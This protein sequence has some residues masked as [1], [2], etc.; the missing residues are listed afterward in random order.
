M[1]HTIIDQSGNVILL[2][3]VFKKKES[4]SGEFRS[5]EKPDRFISILKKYEALVNDQVLTRL[6][7]L[8]DEIDSYLLRVKETGFL[9]KNIRLFNDKISYETEF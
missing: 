5:V 6:D 1:K 4:Y 7:E 2:T 3:E 8:E 9:V